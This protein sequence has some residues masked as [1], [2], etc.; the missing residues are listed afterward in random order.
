MKLKTQNHPYIHHHIHFYALKF[1]DSAL[2]N[3]RRQ[4]P[5]AST[6]KIPNFIIFLRLCFYLIFV[7]VEFSMLYHARYN[8]R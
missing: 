6:F 1:I 2:E 7:M 3:D 4:N 5:K 8:P